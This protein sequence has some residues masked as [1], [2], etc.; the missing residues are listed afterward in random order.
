MEK[1]LG[2][3]ERKDGIQRI[4]RKRW[5]IFYGY[6]IDGGMGYNYRLTLEYKPTADEVKQIILNQINANVQEEILQGMSWNGREVWLSAENQRNIVLAAS[7]KAPITLK[8][9]TDED[10]ELHTFDADEV[11]AFAAAVQEHIERAIASGRRA[12]S[13]IDWSAYRIE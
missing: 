11:Q 3:T 5:E 4:G 8:L 10:Y 2:A 7:I 1:I 9:G 12:K 13:E 6:G